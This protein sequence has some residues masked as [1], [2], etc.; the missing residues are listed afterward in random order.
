MQPAV[1]ATVQDVREPV[2]LPPPSLNQLEMT[3]PNIPFV[4]GALTLLWLCGTTLIL[5]IWVPRWLRVRQ[6]VRSAMLL[7]WRDAGGVDRDHHSPGLLRW[8]A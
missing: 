4:P 8:L 1:Y 5:S 7:T 3:F 2:K 6:L